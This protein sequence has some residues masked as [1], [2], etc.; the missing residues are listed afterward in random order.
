VTG[1]KPEFPA[2]SL[3]NLGHTRN[4]VSAKIDLEGPAEDG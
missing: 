4:F 1:M 2:G 3:A